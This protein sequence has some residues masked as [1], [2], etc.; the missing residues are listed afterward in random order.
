MDARVEWMIVW[1]GS[2]DGVWK[3]IPLCLFCVLRICKLFR[4]LLRADLLSPEYLSSIHCCVVYLEL[5]IPI[6]RVV[7]VVA[8]WMGGWML[9]V[10]LLCVA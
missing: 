7:L 3:G 4:F 6:V 1:V 8:L 5:R 10:W 9:V 2:E